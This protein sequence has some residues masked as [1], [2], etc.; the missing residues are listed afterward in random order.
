[1]KILEP[2]QLKLIRDETP[3]QNRVVML[4]A[5]AHTRMEVDFLP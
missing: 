2:Y 3:H 1:L 4:Q 5:L